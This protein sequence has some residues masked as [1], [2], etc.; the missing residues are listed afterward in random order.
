[1]AARRHDAPIDLPGVTDRE[2]ATLRRVLNRRWRTPLVRR[3]RRLDADRLVAVPP[4]ELLPKVSGAS[5]AH[6]P[7]RWLACTLLGALPLSEQERSAAVAAL[8]DVVTEAVRPNAPMSRSRLTRGLQ[9]SLIYGL[10]LTAMACIPL[11]T[12]ARGDDEVALA[13]WAL[14]VFCSIPAG[15]ALSPLVITLSVAADLRVREA[16][17]VA[18]G[19]I[20]TVDCIPALAHGALGPHRPTRV[21]S[22]EALH[23]LLPKVP[24][25]A[26]PEHAAD[27]SPALARLLQHDDDLLVLLTLDAIDKAGDGSCLAPVERCATAGRAEPI[28]QRAAELLPLLRARRDQERQAATLLRPAEP[29]AASTLLRAA[30]SSPTDPELL[31]RPAD[32]EEA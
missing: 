17:A 5:M 14:V 11:V 28:R 8:S 4:A 26:Y 7:D 30:P 1:M 16:A 20:G 3:I 2:L 18:L 32:G 23:R 25:D 15:L 29:D 21:A 24:A 27:L 10:V 31:L 22:A 9:R 6:W 13:A 12:W 19:R